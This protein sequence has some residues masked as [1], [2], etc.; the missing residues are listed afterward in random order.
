LK[1][2]KKILK[3][4]KKKLPARRVKIGFANNGNS[5]ISQLFDD[6]ITTPITKG[7]TAPM[8]EVSQVM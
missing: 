8:V 4:H 5:L 6:W 1:S 7:I 3:R 2:T